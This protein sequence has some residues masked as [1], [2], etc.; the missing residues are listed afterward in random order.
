MALES[1]KHA[2]PAASYSDVEV[3]GAINEK[4]LLRKLDARLLP[5]VSILY[6]LSFL[7]RS[8]GKPFDTKRSHRV[9]TIMLIEWICSCKRTYRR[10]DYRPQDDWQ[11]IPYW[12]NVVFR[13]LC[14]V[15]A[16]V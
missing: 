7:D 11:P 2:S 6:L 4:R 12:P 1:D 14:P 13:R 15:R 9:R 16:A 3:S 5:A 10:S 8:N